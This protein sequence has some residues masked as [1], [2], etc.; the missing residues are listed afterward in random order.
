[1]MRQNMKMFALPVKS[2]VKDEKLW[3]IIRLWFFLWFIFVVLIWYPK[4]N[5]ACER[6]SLF[7]VWKNSRL[8]D[9]NIY[10]QW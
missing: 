6:P 4:Q 3:C 7:A 1:M 5:R 10:L 8:Q 2:Q 9:M